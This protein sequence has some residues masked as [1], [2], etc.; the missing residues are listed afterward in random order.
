[1]FGVFV[2]DSTFMQIERVLHIFPTRRWHDYRV[3]LG[4]IES[5]FSN[6]A[7]GEGA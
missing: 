6:A 3:D 7:V 2:V 4:S 1:L 5:A